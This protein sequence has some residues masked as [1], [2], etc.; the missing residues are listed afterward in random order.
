MVLFK[1]G[2]KLIGEGLFV[3]IIV[4]VGINYDGKLSQ[5]FELIDVVSEVGVDVV[6]F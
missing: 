6:K 3:F 1:I 5:V 4:E 2:L